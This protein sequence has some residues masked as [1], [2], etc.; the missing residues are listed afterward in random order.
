MTSKRIVFMGTPE[1]AIPSLGAIIEAGHQIIRVYSQPPRRAGRGHRLKKSSIHLFASKNDID[2]LTPK[3][4]DSMESKMSFHDLNPDLAI[5]MAYGIILPREIINSPRL[6]CIN[7]HLSLLPRWRG[8]API[9]RAIMAGD[10][11]T[12]VS[13]MQMDEGLDTGPIIKKYRTSI[14]ADTTANSLHD[15]LAQLAARAICTTLKES[16]EGQFQ[17]IP[18]SSDGVSYAK[19]IMREEGLI[20]WQH[21]SADLVRRIRALNPWP[22]TWFEY[23]GERIRILSAEEGGRSGKPGTVLDETPLIACGKGSLRPL[24]MQRPGKST[25]DAKSFL[26]GY[27]LPVG[28][29]L[30]T[31]KV[32]T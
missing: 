9:Q 18:Q 5:V 7:I 16:D 28:Q 23:G 30:S 19:K 13:I 8:A 1:I 22:G 32:N 14:N 25:T 12:G 26:R 31:P 10:T 27:K 21:S 4:F 2:V 24:E 11:E 3:N 20:N 17:S 29:L 6:G 15:E